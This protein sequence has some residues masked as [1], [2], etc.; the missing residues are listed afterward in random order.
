LLFG[1]AVTYFTLTSLYNPELNGSLNMH[2]NYTSMTFC[3]NHVLEV[4]H[5]R[6]N[7]HFVDYI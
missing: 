6:D 7:F 1:S 5:K 3:N 2:D 4:M